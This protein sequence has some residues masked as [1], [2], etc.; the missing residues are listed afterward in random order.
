MEIRKP[1]VLVIKSILTSLVVGSLLIASSGL[2]VRSTTPTQLEKVLQTGELHVLSSNGPTTFYEGSDGLT[3]FEYSLVKGFADSL[4][5]K[6]VI[7]EE[8]DTNE[9]LNDVARQQFHLAAAGLT[10]LENRANQVTFST[11]FM[12]ITQQ[13]IYNSRLKQPTSVKDLQD[14]EVLVVSSASHSERFKALQAQFPELQWRAVINAE[15]IDLLEMI[16]KGEADYAVIDSSA[17]D[18]NRYSY[19]KAQLA[20]DVSDPQPLAWAFPTSRDTSLFDA[21]QKYLGNIKADGTLAKVTEE[22]FDRHIEEVTTGE[23]MAF[24]YQLEQRLPQWIDYMKS[25]AAEFNLDWHLLAAIGYQESH[26]QADARSH[27]G[28]RGLMMLTK[29]TAKAMGVVDREDPRESIYGGAK[30]L[31]IVLERLPKRIQGEDRLNMALAAY[32]QGLGHVEDARV[33]TERMGGNPSKWED[34]RKYMPLLAKQQYYSQAKHGYMRGWEPVGFVDNVRNYHKII[35]WHQ[36]QLEFRLATT[37]TGNRLSANTREVSD[38][39]TENGS[40]AQDALSRISV[41]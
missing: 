31:S 1:P 32:N 27:T 2:L 22:F 23:A 18:L 26:W 40:V 11:P 24:T 41:L 19:P 35:A 10:A 28:V 34:V 3:G 39:K 8:S 13:L 16:N 38:T 9:M 30:Y 36:Q 25:A 12:Q 4:G 7:E 14:K 33:L 29:N 20:F 5:V 21:A 6:L 17:Y 37:N 15:M